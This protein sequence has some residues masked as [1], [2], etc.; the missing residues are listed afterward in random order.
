MKQG[1]SVRNAWFGIVT[2]VIS[3]VIV[4]V[5]FEW[6]L[7]TMTGSMQSS[8][9]MDEGFILFDSRLGWKLN[10]GWEG[11]HR[12]HDFE[13]QYQVNELGFRGDALEFSGESQKVF[14]LGDSFTFG[15]GVDEGETFPDFLNSSAAGAH[16]DFF[17]LSVP[18]YAPD[19]Q[20]ILLDDLLS[21]RPDTLVWVIYLG[22]DLLDI[23]YPFPL[24]AGYGKP[25]YVLDGNRLR[26]ENSPVPLKAKTPK[27]Q[28]M[29]VSS[30][31]LEGFDLYPIWQDLLADS[32]IGTR[33]NS[34][35]G[36][37]ENALQSHIEERLKSDVALFLAMTDRARTMVRGQGGEMAFVLMPGSGYFRENTVPGVY[38]KSTAR[39]LSSELKDREYRVVNLGPELA[40]LI[41]SEK[42]LF[43]PNEGHLT[44][45][46]H[47]A[48][49]GIL[50]GSGLWDEQ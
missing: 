47:K 49:A 2:V 27:Y 38:Q 26:L 5:V 7:R 50:A 41:N 18:G 11:K 21:Y 15:L 40:N 8:E 25:Y 4:L 30:A 9:S 24:Q 43:H 28:A 1:N 6:A 20:L 36:F 33:I 17:N 48:V 42:Q 13:V 16:T 39:A 37:D 31:I 32:Q 3:V 34:I 46:G 45:E 12:H 22:N 19:Q 10:P 29:S 35:I 44:P 14:F 23:R